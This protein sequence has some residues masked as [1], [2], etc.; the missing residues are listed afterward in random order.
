MRDP[1]LGSPLLRHLFGE[2]K[3]VAENSLLSQ[4]SFR[5]I[6]E[7][8]RNRYTEEDSESLP[9]IEEYL[10]HKIYLPSTGKSF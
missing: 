4:T 8:M 9:G 10:R 3:D 2:I 1:N 5:E 6:F 7:A